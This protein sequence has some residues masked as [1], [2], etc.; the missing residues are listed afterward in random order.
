MP[1]LATSPRARRA[2]DR[3]QAARLFGVDRPPL[4]EPVQVAT[5]R[6]D[7]QAALRPIAERPGPS[8]Q[9]EGSLEGAPPRSRRPAAADRQH[10]DVVA[11]VLIPFE[12]DVTRDANAGGERLDR[13][14]A[15]DEA[16]HVD[17]ALA[18]ANKENPAEQKRVGVQIDRVEGRMQL[19]RLL[20]DRVTRRGRQRVQASLGPG[21]QPSTHERRRDGR[22]PHPRPPLRWP[23]HAD[24]PRSEEPC[25]GGPVADRK[26]VVGTKTLGGPAVQFEQ[27]PVLG[28]VLGIILRRARAAIDAG[29]ALQRQDV[30][31][32]GCRVRFSATRGLASMFETRGVSARL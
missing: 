24:W 32:V 9:V 20:G 15:L 16:G 27:R 5:R 22:S 13:D 29:L 25:L 19:P 6:D 31:S 28:D 3:Q 30:T 21:D 2:L 12:V 7:R 4:E 10:G 8:R 23:L 18:P 14:T 11:G 1:T 17:V 26:R